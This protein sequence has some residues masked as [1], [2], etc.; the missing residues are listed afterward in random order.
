MEQSYRERNDATRAQLH[1]LLQRLAPAGFARALGGG[2]TV[3]AAL[4]HLAFWDRFAALLV[5]QWQRTGFQRSLHDDEIL[6]RAALPAWLAAR[7]D[8]VAPEVRA[9]AA[10]ADQ[11]AAVVGAELAAAVA[12]GGEWWVCDRNLHRAEHLAQIEQALPSAS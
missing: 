1:A 11:R 10:E 6:N 7:S 3:Q 8:Q 5:E 12:A 9:A 2:W 4:M